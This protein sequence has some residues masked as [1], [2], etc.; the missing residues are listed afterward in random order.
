[1]KAS[2]FILAIVMLPLFS[3]SG[4][5]SDAMKAK[6]QITKAV[7]VGSIQLDPGEYK[8]TWT[9][10]G[11]RAEVTFSRGKKV[12]ATVPAQATQER[13]EYEG[14][15]LLIDDASNTLVGVSLP[16]VSL[17]FVSKESTQPNSGN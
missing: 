1:M 3:L 2:K 9:V 17:S 13:S 14:P 6:I 7:H 16:E 12:I 5:A 10:N 8:I 15:A 4:W 11:P